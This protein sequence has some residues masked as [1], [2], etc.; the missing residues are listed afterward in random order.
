V[1]SSLNRFVSPHSLTL[2]SPTTLFVYLQFRSQGAL[3]GLDGTTTLDPTNAIYICM[4][5]DPQNLTTLCRH[6]ARYYGLEM[7]QLQFSHPSL[8]WYFSVITQHPTPMDVPSS[9]DDDADDLA[10]VDVKSGTN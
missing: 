3:K 6:Y 7:D 8:N 1:S 9:T 2:T 10:R 4:V 5:D